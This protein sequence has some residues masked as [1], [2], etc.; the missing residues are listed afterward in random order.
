[1]RNGIVAWVAALALAVPSLAL[2]SGR[3]D[4]YDDRDRHDDECGYD[5]GYGHD[6]YGHGDGY[7]YDD[8]YDDR[9]HD[10]GYGHD[11]YDGHGEAC[12]ASFDLVIAVASND[13]SHHGVVCCKVVHHGGQKALVCVDPEDRDRHDDYD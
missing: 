4:R 13:G 8:T 12:P 10:G 1:M 9:Y 11:G 6:G 3:D 2:A 5:D 7:G